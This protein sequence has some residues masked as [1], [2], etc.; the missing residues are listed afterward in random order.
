M[1]RLGSGVSECTH[2]ACD[3]NPINT[4]KS[5]QNNQMCGWVAWRPT[6]SS[7]PIE[8]HERRGGANGTKGLQTIN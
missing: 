1:L 5:F 2:D 7:T 3:N 6:A 8:P 4:T